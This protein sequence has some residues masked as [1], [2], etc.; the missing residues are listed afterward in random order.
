MTT[1]SH[2]SSLVISAPAEPGPYSCKAC[3]ALGDPWVHLRMCSTCGYIGC[4]DS[5]KNKHATQH[6]RASGHPLARSV[7][8]GETWVWC[9]IDRVMLE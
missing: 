1:C 6:H 7:E 4:C 8:P 2:R 9:Y 5:S 3:L